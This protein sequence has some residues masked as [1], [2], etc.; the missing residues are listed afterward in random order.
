MVLTKKIDDD[1]DGE[2]SEPE[3]EKDLQ[4]TTTNY[5]GWKVSYKKKTDGTK[6]LGRRRYLAKLFRENEDLSTLLPPGK[7]HRSAED[8]RAAG[9]RNNTQRRKRVAAWRRRQAAAAAV[10]AGEAET[11]QQ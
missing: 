3:K 8:L 11:E 4:V 1:E 6:A 10:P 2:E 9:E 5:L 7:R